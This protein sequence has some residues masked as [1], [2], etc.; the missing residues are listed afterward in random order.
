[1]ITKMALPVRSFNFERTFTPEEFEALPEF[2]ELYEL[3]NGKL[4]KKPMPGD[5]HGRIARRISNELF[6]LDPKEI[7]GTL[8]L[9]TTFDVGTGWMPIPD[10][11]FIRASRV[12]AKSRKSIKGVPDLVVEIHS[13]T[14]LRSKPERDAAAQKI[15]EWQKV[16][17][18]LIWAIN[19]QKQEIEIYHLTQPKPVRVLHNQD[20]LVGEDVIP[21]FKLKVSELLG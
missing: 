7:L 19:P 20:E 15:L 9:S 3:V 17:V 13:P 4:V 1:M 8:W 6:M 18:G 2:E 12:P 14:D 21:G 16:G 10:L 11:G 5:E